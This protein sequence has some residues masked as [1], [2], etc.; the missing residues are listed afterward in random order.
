MVLS[1]GPQGAALFDALTSRP[2][3]R[4]TPGAMIAIAASVAVHG[5]A[6][7]YLYNMAFH[8]MTLPP[9][10]E[11]PPIV[12]TM[13]SIPKPPPPPTPEVTQPVKPRKS[14]ETIFT[15]AKPPTYMPPVVETP[16][17]VGPTV[18]PEVVLPPAPKV[19]GH[20]AWV[21]KPD[22]DQLARYYPSR[23]QSLGLNGMATL[24]CIVNAVGTVR[25]CAV[26][27]ETPAGAGFGAAAVKLSRFFRMQPQTE[28]GRPVDGAQVSIPLRFSLE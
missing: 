10:A 5:V 24:A 23:A 19:I 9:P 1:Q 4:L 28:D 6:G 25:D 20:P 11:G 22:G 2:A 18:T 14:V 16:L 26:V 8:P 7:A 27:S 3:F 15:P 21:A 12:I 17:P 13:G